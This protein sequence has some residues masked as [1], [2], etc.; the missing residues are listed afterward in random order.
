[1]TGINSAAAANPVN[2]V[3]MLL[4]SS[5]KQAMDCDEAN[6]QL[7]TIVD[8]QKA[9]PY[10]NRITLPAG[11]A[12]DWLNY[13]KGLNLVDI[14]RQKLGNVY[15]LNNDWVTL[16]T[17]Y[18][19][20]ILHMFA[21]PSLIACMFNQ[22][23]SI[24]RTVLI[25]TIHTLYP[26]IKTELHLHWSESEIDALSDQ[27]IE[28]FLQIKLLHL[29]S[30]GLLVNADENAREFDTLQI[31]G[32][33]MMP[34]LERYYISV[35]M[36]QKFGS[37]TLSAGELEKLSHQ[38]AERLSLLNGLNAPEFFDRA[39][40][41]KFIFGLRRSQLLKTS[42]DNK[43]LFGEEIEALAAMADSILRRSV[44]LTIKQTA[45]KSD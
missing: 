43:L 17:Y 33:V 24:D 20:N 29:D 15:Q 31:L 35:S 9:L 10:T 6:Y 18:R 26:F 12:N 2:L 39:L 23:K 34:T 37:G 30:N 44:R 19:N 8:M 22:G 11:D 3:A 36:L 42:D 13:C 16:S 27:W 25:N 28:H 7:Q 41:K 5:D 14:K 45:R 21:L 32:H 40:F 4:L 1:M 38:M